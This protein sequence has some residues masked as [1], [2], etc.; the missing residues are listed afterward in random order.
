MWTDFEMSVQTFCRDLLQ[1]GSCQRLRRSSDPM[2][3]AFV[4]INLTTGD[5]RWAH[6]V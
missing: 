1:A 4:R 2:T 5:S 6:F 3:A